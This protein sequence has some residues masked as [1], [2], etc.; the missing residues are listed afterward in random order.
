MYKNNSDIIQ[1]KVLNIKCFLN[2]MNHF[3]EKLY[4]HKLIKSTYLINFSGKKSSACNNKRIT[5]FPIY[6]NKES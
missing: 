4:L 6:A 5:I 3:Q 1:S 2:Y